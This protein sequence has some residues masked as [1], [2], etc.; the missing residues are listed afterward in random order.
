MA[1]KHINVTSSA[2]LLRGKVDRH[3]THLK[4]ALLPDRPMNSHK[5][6]DINTGF[7]NSTVAAQTTSVVRRNSGSGNKSGSVTYLLDLASTC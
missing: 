3:L 7:F 6:R 1:I 5:P 4:Q 2:E